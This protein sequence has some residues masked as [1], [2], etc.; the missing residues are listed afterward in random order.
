MHRAAAWNDPPASTNGA[1]WLKSDENQ[2]HKDD[3]IN[4]CI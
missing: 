2:T 3:I 1:K 4:L